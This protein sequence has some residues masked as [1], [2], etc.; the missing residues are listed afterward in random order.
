MRR[1]TQVL[2]NHLRARVPVRSP[3]LVHSLGLV[4]YRQVL[5]Q[6]LRPKHLKPDFLGA[7]TWTLSKHVA[8]L[9]ILRTR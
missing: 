9:Q 4:L 8:S 3:T 5:D 7:S 1:V 2:L 6:A